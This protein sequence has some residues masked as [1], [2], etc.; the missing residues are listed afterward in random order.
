MLFSAIRRE[1]VRAAAAVHGDVVPVSPWVSLLGCRWGSFQVHRA[2]VGPRKS[3]MRSC[4]PKKK[5]K[6]CKGFIPWGIARASIFVHKSTM[7]SEFLGL[8]IGCQTLKS[9]TF[10]LKTTEILPSRLH[11]WELRAPRF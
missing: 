11:T 10:S 4:L 2:V 3:P 8:S 1:I 6:K 5:K 9:L 7:L